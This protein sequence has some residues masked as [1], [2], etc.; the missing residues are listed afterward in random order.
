MERDK[1]ILC[2]IALTALVLSLPGCARTA[3]APGGK[4]LYVRLGGATMIAAIVDQFVTN[5]VA[6]SRING[7]FATTDIA[8]FRGH[9]IDQLCMLTGGPCVYQGRDMQS[10]HAGMHITIMEFD[11]L[12]EDLALALD[13]C[14]VPTQEK[15]MVVELLRPMEKEIVE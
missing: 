11:A 9:L 6:D 13:R 14:K 7:R 8:K 1:A 2:G 4:P 12:V 5:V 10:S 15:R 3:T